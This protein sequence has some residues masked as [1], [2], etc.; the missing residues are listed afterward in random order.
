MTTE[1]ETAVAVI[2]H[3]KI[4]IV[5]NGRGE[6]LVPVR[7]ICQAL[8][9]DEESQRKKI[10]RDSILSSTA[11]TMT[12]VGADGKNRDMLCLPMEFIPGWLFSFDISRV[13]EGAR[14]Q[15]KRF[16]WECYRALYRYFTGQASGMVE[17]YR[18]ENELLAEIND[19]KSELQAAEER[20]SEVK[21]RI[22]R[23][24]DDLAALQQERI[25]GQPRLP[26]NQ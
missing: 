21:G 12:A 8:G 18:R 19:A 2:N 20:R 13:A 25:N 3:A 1:R 23:L 22:R 5:T 7:P 24:Q 4:T 26:F 16:Q 11:V 14:E 6:Q 15:L 10:Y 9:I 17:Q